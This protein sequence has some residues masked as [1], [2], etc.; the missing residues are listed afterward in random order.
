M[1]KRMF[2]FAAVLIAMLA[3]CSSGHREPFCD[4]TPGVR[5]IDELYGRLRA[6]AAASKSLS[7]REIAEVRYGQ[8]KAPLIM[9]SY[10][11]GGHAAKRPAVLID[12]GVHGNEPAPVVYAE[13]LIAALADGT[14]ALK[15][16][17]L[18][19]IP[20]VNPWGWSHD[21]RYN[22]DG[23]DINRDFGMSRSQ[24]AK[25]I[26]GLLKGRKYDLVLDLHEDPK[27]KGVYVYQYGRDSRKLLEN[28]I[29]ESAAMGYAIENNVDMILLKT[30]N[31][32]LDAPMWGLWY[33]RLTN[34][35]SLSNHCRLFNSA[36]VFTVETPMNISLEKRCLFHEKA[37]RFLVRHS[38]GAAGLSQKGMVDGNNNGI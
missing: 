38:A 1:M 18:D 30:K 20:V 14:S 23:R 16:F 19:V 15:D 36:N 17:D 6:K 7:V 37:V 33:V 12:A 28:L 8:Y 9:I 24:E 31:G 21:K 32:I 13:Q 26:K 4:E 10:R 2:F 11:R 25:A 34:Q 35:L 5:S 27:A 29:G 22:R 3:A